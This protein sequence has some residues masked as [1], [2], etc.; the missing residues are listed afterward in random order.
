MNDKIVIKGAKIQ[1]LASVVK[2]RKGEYTKLLQNFQKQGFVRVRIDGE[3]VE[4]SDEISIDKKHN[5]E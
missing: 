5:I 4:L 3:V 2:A 1:V